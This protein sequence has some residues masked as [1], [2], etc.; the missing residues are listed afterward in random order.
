VH[1]GGVRVALNSVSGNLSLVN[2]P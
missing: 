1:G 2:Q